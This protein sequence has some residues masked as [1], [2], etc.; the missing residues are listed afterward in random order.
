MGSFSK[1]QSVFEWCFHPDINSKKYTKWGHPLFSFL[2]GTAISLIPM[3]KLINFLERKFPSLKQEFPE[4]TQS[5]LIL[6][7][8]VYMGITIISRVNV[9]GPVA[10][11]DF[12]WACNISILM[13]IVGLVKKSHLMISSSMILVSIDQVKF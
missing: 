11:Y 7:L 13:M 9:L 5:K 10:L 6:A 8:C 12:L 2:F 3:V 1:I 4:W